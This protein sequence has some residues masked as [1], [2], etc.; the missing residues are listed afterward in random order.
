MSKR[1][2]TLA[3]VCL[4]AFSTGGCIGGMAVTGKVREFNLDVARNRWAREAVFLVLHVVPAYPI[5]AVA[6]LVIVN[7]IEFHTGINPV[8][9]KRRIA[10]VG[11]THTVEVDGV[12]SLSTLREDGSIDLVLVEPDGIRHFVNLKRGD[13]RVAARDET[14]RELVSV[15]LGA[16]PVGR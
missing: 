8:S 7:S 2:G 3:L 5:A 9:G 4:T 10:R 11:Q 14:G 16:V 6:D 15:P 13:A 12:R 1:I